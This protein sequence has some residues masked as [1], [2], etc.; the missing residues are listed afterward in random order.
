MRKKAFTLVELLVVISIIA[1]LLAI[2]MPTLQKARMQAQSVVCK[3]N[4]K[5]LG[6]VLEFYKISNK[7][8]LLP[9]YE[10]PSPGNFIYWTDRLTKNNYINFNDRNVFF[11]PSLTPRNW[12]EAETKIGLTWDNIG[13]TFGLRQWSDPKASQRDAADLTVPH[14]VDIIKSPSS[15]FLLADSIWILDNFP[16]YNE[17]T[18]RYHYNRTQC[19]AISLGAGSG[20]YSRFHVRHNKAANTLFADG[21]I[22]AVKSDYFETLRDT[23]SG[24]MGPLAW[25]MK[26]YVWTPLK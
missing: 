9:T 18:T 15:F 5:Q 4:M 13:C 1:L 6:L 11:C 7:N 17:A 10:S 14:K 26:Y 16:G 22:A 8:Y 2:L 12:K 23:Q 20:I 21:H 19:Y 25:K 24:Y 3:S